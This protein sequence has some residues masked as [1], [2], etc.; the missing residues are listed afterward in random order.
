MGCIQGQFDTEDRIRWFLPA[1]KQGHIEAQYRLGQAYVKDRDYEEAKKWLLRAAEKGHT[2]AQYELGRHYVFLDLTT[3]QGAEWTYKAA[4]K[5]HV[6]AQRS[7][8][9]KHFFGSGVTKDVNEAVKWYRKAAEQGDE[10]AKDE[11]W[12]LGESW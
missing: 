9:H 12:K 7:L 11:L 2:N 4:I 6:E 10:F 5:G 1:A 8:G 3:E